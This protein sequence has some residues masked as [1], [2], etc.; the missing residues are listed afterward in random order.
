MPEHPWR[1]IDLDVYE[2]HMSDAQVGQLQA[3][4]A[5]TREQLADY[6]PRAVGVLGV[7]GGNGLDLVDPE[8]VQAVY[9]YDI[10]PAY[11]DVCRTR[12]EPVFGDRLHLVECA[13]GPSLVLETTDLL[14]ANL[15]VEYVGEREFA[16]FAAK[17]RAS[18]KVLSCVTQLNNAAG[19]VSKTEFSDSFDGLASIA[20][21]IV[22]GRFADA[23]V[24]G[25]FE[26]VKERT[27]PLPNGK[28][29]CR[30]DFRSPL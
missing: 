14:I 16:A 19:L 9:G 13:I 25:G 27:Y 8:T 30:Q 20:T 26:A 18:I 6:R 7:A 2:R 3:L 29:L 21:D 5:I 15:I 4:H 23:M 17:N 12:Y 22:T 28:L 11:L 1:H 24:E 10:N